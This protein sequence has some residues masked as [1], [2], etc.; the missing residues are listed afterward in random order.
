MPS[1]IFEINEIKDAYIKYAVDSRRYIL[2]VQLQ[3]QDEKKILLETKNNLKTVVPKNTTVTIIIHTTSGVFN[4]TVKVLD[5]QYSINTLTYVVSSPSNWKYIQLRTSTRTKV[6]IPIKITFND[7]FNINEVTYDISL[8]G[9]SF[10]SQTKLND[11]Y[12]KITGSVTLQLSDGNLIS[13]NVKYIRDVQYIEE[14]DGTTKYLYVF[15]FIDINT[16][17]LKKI[18]TYFKNKVTDV[19]R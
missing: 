11:V 5:I 15:R 10:Y 18:Q 6:N 4:A 12:K 7:N 2:K 16:I 19:I 1:K 14:Y 9:V 13:S 3:Y 8:N 17:N